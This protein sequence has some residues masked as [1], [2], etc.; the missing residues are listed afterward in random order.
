M[1][2]H[3][4]FTWLRCFRRTRCRGGCEDEEGEK[5]KAEGEEEEWHVVKKEQ[6]RTR[7]CGAIW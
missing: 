6:D 2:G 5:G 3:E 7:V 4:T 1:S